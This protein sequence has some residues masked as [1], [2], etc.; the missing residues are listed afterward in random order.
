MKKIVYL[1]I[2]FA[3]I[4][5]SDFLDKSP[6]KNTQVEVTTAEQ[7]DALLGNYSA[8]FQEA[9]KTLSQE[10]MIMNGLQHFMIVILKRL[11]SHKQN[12]HYGISKLSKKTTEKDYGAVNTAKYFT[13]IWY[14]LIYLK[15][16]VLNR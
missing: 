8:F 5:C 7:L 14:Y 10:R 13:Q 11:P 9:N 15:Y 1:L 16:L 6:S 4:S 12:M 3:S 2:V